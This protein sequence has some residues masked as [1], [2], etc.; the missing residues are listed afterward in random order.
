L[1]PRKDLVER[2]KSGERVVVGENAEIPGS[3]HTVAKVRLT[4]GNGDEKLVANGVD[5]LGD[6]LGLPL[7]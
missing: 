4:E 3:F 2:L 7:Y 6:E 1:L 5:G